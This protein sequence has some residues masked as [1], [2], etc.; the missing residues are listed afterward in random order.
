MRPDTLREY[1]DCRSSSDFSRMM[2]RLERRGYP[3][4]DSRY[5]RHVKA[6]VDRYVNPAE[7]D[8]DE[9]AAVAAIR[10]VDGGH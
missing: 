2:V 5:H 7:E 8:P 10:I 3:G 9:A 4:I 6:V 1:L